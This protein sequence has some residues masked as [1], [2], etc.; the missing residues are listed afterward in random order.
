MWKKENRN[1][2]KGFALG[3]GITLIARDVLPWLAPLARPL[4]RQLAR[5]AILGYKRT[6]EKS[7][8]MAESLEDLVAE[9]Q[10][11]LQEERAAVKQPD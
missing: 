9:V 7:A 8:E 6:R 5:A 11:E 2:L 1:L 3:A 4:T 10:W